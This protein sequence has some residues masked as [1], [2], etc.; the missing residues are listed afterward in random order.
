[1]KRMVTLLILFAFLTN[2]LMFSLSNAQEQAVV[3][4][5]MPD[6]TVVSMTPSQLSALAG[7]PGITISP[8]TPTLGPTEVAIPL[9]AELGGGYIVGTPSAIASALEATGIASGLSASDIIGAAAA[10]GVIPVG[11]LAGTVATL[12]TGG[13]IAAAGIVGAGIVAGI[14]SATGG[15]GGGGGGGPTPPGHHAPPGGGGG[16]IIPPGHH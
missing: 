8:T 3:V 6:G 9:P 5:T 12:G 16:G 10:A 11:A 2:P 14:I 13:T 7:Q 4:M 1:M 15:G